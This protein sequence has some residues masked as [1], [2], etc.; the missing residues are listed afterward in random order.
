MSA[1]Q[2]I[3]AAFLPDFPTPVRERRLTVVP[4][5]AM[6]PKARRGTRR[7]SGA[8]TACSRRGSRTGVGN[9]GSTSV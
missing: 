7:R 4:A 3:D 5:T 9:S 8:G 6:T 1:P 2:A